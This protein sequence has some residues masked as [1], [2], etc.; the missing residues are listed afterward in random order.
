MIDHAKLK[1][2]LKTLDSAPKAINAAKSKYTSELQTIR[3]L[4]KG[5][6]YS[7]NYINRQKEAAKKERDRT[8]KS[9]AES[10]ITAYETVVENNDYSAEQLALDDPKFTNAL[11]IVTLLGKNMPHS[12]QA[13]VLAQFRGNPA[14][15][16]VLEQAY[17]KNGLYFADMAHEMQKPISTQTLEEM[18]NCLAG[19]V[20]NAEQKGIYDLD[21]DKIY[22]SQGDYAKQAQRLGYDLENESVFDYALAEESRRLE[23]ASYSS[24]PDTRSHAQAQSYALEK[25][26]LE[27][28]AAR[29]NGGDEAGIFE[30]ALAQVERLATLPSNGEG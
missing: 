18:Q 29:K 21:T 19:Y 16:S 11:N 12:T 1:S 3:E 17:R 25:A 26:R 2:A 23:L 10:M 9:L 4:E 6:N 15:L 5:G 7:P 28:A 27:L 30:K 24:D 8:V 20:Y 22:W 14:A 13:S